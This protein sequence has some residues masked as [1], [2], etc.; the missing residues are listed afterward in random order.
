M[1]AARPATLVLSSAVFLVLCAVHAPS[2]RPY[3]RPHT[4]I[5]MVARLDARV[6]TIALPRRLTESSIS[7]HSPWKIRRKAVLERSDPT[8]GEEC[9][10]GP[11]SLPN[12]LSNLS[13]VDFIF[14]RLPSNPPLR[15]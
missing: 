2:F 3:V 11:A 10:L 8:A 13:L 12:D 9:D 7:D 14:P 15:C 4:S 5:E 1:F 6:A